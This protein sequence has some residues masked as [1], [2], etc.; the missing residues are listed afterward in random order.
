M[1]FMIPSIYCLFF[2]TKQN[3]TIS[4]PSYVGTL[5]IPETLM[6]MSLVTKNTEILRMIEVNS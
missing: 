3:M 1:T 4:A 6:N 5:E 2:K